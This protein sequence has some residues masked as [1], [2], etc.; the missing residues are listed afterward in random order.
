M[1]GCKKGIIGAKKQLVGLRGPPDWREVEN[2]IRR[3]GCLMQGDSSG[4]HAA[5][6]ETMSAETT[7]KS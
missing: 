7:L 4:D 2:P 1:Q 6:A 3:R 5:A